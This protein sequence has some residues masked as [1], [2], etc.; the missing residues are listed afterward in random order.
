MNTEPAA[1]T[2]T[3]RLRASAAGA[4][5]VVLVLAVYLPSLGGGFVWD[6]WLLVQQNPLNTGELSLRSIWF[7]TDFPLALVTLRAEWLAFGNGSD[8]LIALIFR[9]FFDPEDE[10]VFT[11]YTYSAYVAYAEALGIAHRVLPMGEDFLID[12]GLLDR[13]VD[14]SI[15]IVAHQHVQATAHGPGGFDDLCR[16]LIREYN[17]AWMGVSIA[18]LHCGGNECEVVHHDLKSCLEQGIDCRRTGKCERIGDEGDGL[19]HLGS[20]A[21]KGTTSTPGVSA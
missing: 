20:K 6:D 11:Q 4:V 7:S 13:S 2:S 1:P 17:D 8:E 3:P 19:C 5:L 16:S 15:G 18:L 9:T 14:R 21:H 12:L 10:A